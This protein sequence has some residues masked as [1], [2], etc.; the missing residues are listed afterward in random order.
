MAKT[1]LVRLKK[2]TIGCTEDQKR[3]VS[4]LGLKRIGHQV[5]IKDNPAMRGQL[6]KVQHLISVEVKK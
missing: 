6:L 2:S 4:V 5:E 1:F 3:T